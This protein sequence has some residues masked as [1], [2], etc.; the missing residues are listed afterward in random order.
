M[1]LIAGALTSSS[2][3]S[4]SAHWFAPELFMPMEFGCKK[5]VQTW[6]T[7]VYVFAC[8]CIEVHSSLSAFCQCTSPESIIYVYQL[9][10][11]NPPF[12]TLPDLTIMMQVIRGV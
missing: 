12:Y 1:D 10:T 9:Y 3:H 4:G 6:A 7:D 11:G 2:N 8:V 5:F